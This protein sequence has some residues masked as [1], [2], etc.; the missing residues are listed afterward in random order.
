LL[1]HNI[2]KHAGTPA[3]SRLKH[4]AVYNAGNTDCLLIIM[5]CLLLRFLQCSCA[6][7]LQLLQMR[8]QPAHSMQQQQLPLQQG[9]FTTTLGIQQ[10]H[11]LHNVLAAALLRYLW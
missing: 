3:E 1:H 8:R 2:N 10:Q 4:A 5:S 7:A 6:S 11:K 9:L